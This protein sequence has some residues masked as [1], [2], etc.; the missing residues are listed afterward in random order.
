[1]VMDMRRDG[2]VR[3]IRIL[4]RLSTEVDCV[5]AE[6]EAVCC[7]HLGQLVS[8][9][10]LT[11]EEITERLREAVK[12]APKCCPFTV[13]ERSPDPRRVWDLYVQSDSEFTEAGLMV[14]EVA[15]AVLALLVIAGV[16]QG[17]SSDETVNHAVVA[18]E[19]WVELR[20]LALDVDEGAVGVGRGGDA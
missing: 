8:D 1:M 18:I 12:R 6:L 19:S 20:G 13:S 15:A 10:V 3:A 5:L 14:G 4:R 11:V 16:V 17:R 9:G 7:L 2:R